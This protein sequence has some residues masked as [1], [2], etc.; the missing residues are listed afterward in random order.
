MDR[1]GGD[2]ELHIH[3]RVFISRIID[4]QGVGEQFRVLSASDPHREK[5]L[6]AR[7]VPEP[8]P[9]QL[10]Q[11]PVYARGNG[12]PGVA[13]HIIINEKLPLASFSRV[14]HRPAVAPVNVEEGVHQLVAYNPQYPRPL[15]QTRLDSRD[16]GILRIKVDIYLPAVLPVIGH[17]KMQVSTRVHA[18]AVRVA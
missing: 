9:E 18:Q 16:T 13:V 3:S 1:G 17:A 6:P 15:L 8:F 12:R 2:T 11:E 5:P 4:Q 7:D 14:A 10:R